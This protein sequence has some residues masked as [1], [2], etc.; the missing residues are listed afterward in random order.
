MLA[1]RP[2]TPADETRVLEINVEAQPNVAALDGFELA[3]LSN[4]SRT[5]I[6]AADVEALRGY[7]LTFTGEDAY[8]GEEFLSLR[9]LMSQ[10]FMYIDQVAVA[11]SERARGIGRQ[12][13]ESL[14]HT[15]SER[16][17]R[18]LCCEVNTR[19]A[20]PG[21]LAFH[22]RLGFDTLSSMATRDGREVV[23]LQKLLTV[24]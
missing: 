16:G 17:I 19:P 18:Y 13:Y 24:R 21:S 14:E 10:P 22:A 5:H 23:L 2:L 12:L 15:A 11:R 3:R 4:L 8:D 9:K 7:A 20:N 6:V 1:I